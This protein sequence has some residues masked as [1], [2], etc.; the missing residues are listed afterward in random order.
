MKKLVLF[1]ISFLLLYLACATKKPAIKE[2]EK[3]E[4]ES[5]ATTFE[6]L[7]MLKDDVVIT[8]PKWEI[9]EID[10]DALLPPGLKIIDTSNIS[11]DEMVHGWRVQIGYSML[12]DQAIELS[13]RASNKLEE[14]VYLDFDAPF[15]KVR[16]GDCNLRKEAMAV[17]EKV[18]KLGFSD[19]LIIPTMVYKYPELRSQR[20]KEKKKAEADSLNAEPKMET[21]AQTEIKN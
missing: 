11:L 21:D 12:V 2:E 15:H 19:A 13:D 16:V 14:V 8:P 7:S 5:I 18:K 20:E 1:F 4:T 17:L 10:Y 9:K 3:E 6:P